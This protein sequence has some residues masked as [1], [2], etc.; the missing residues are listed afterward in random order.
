MV[1]EMEEKGKGGSSGG[2][3]ITKMQ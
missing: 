1:M 3:A 2:C